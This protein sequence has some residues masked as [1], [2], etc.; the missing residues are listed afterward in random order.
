MKWRGRALNFYT[1]NTIGKEAWITLISLL[2]RDH[3]KEVSKKNQVPHLKRT[4]EVASWVMWNSLWNDDVLWMRSHSVRY[5]KNF[6]RDHQFGDT[7]RWVD[8]FSGMVLDSFFVIGYIMQIFRYLGKC[9]CL[10]YMRIG[11][12]M[13]GNFV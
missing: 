3:E 6:E 8:S 13:L 10:C 12:L 7:K 2:K 9:L 4:S 5:M 11:R 1:S